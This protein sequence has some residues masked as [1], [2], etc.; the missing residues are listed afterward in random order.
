M[1]LKAEKIRQITWD[2][3][4]EHGLVDIMDED[5][6]ENNPFLQDINIILEL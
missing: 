1:N 4:R 5:V 6:D 2:Y 3:I